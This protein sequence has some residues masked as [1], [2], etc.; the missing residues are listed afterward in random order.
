[1]VCR[2]G[3]ILSNFAKGDIWDI[4]ERFED[5]AAAFSSPLG[6]G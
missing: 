6:R 1:M 5:T 3:L 2:K 4:T